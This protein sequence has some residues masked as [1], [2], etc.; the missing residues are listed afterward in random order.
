[1][2][3][4]TAADFQPYNPSTIV[5]GPLALYSVLVDSI[6]QTHMNEDFAEVDTKAAGFNPFVSP[7]QVEADLLGD[8]EPII[9]GPDG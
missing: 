5:A 9:I 1:M 4:L 7:S 3:Q 2:A 6:M 8:V